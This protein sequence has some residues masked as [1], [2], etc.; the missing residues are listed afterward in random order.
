MRNMESGAG[1]FSGVTVATTSYSSLIIDLAANATQTGVSFDGGS[2]RYTMTGATARASLTGSKL[3][4]ITDGG[5]ASDG[6]LAVPVITSPPAA[7]VLPS[8][9]FS[10]TITAS[11]NPTTFASSNVPAPLIG[12]GAFITGAAPSTP[13]TYTINLSATNTAGNGNG[14]LTLYVNPTTAPVITSPSTA[15]G[16]RGQAFTTYQIVASNPPTSWNAVGLPA[17]LTCSSTGA[18]TGTPTVVGTTTVSL[19]ASNANGTGVANLTITIVNSAGGT[20]GTGG[21]AASGGGGCG[22]GAT[23]VLLFVGLALCGVVCRRR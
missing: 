5:L 16:V 2:S 23:A 14:T 8:A 15:S 10:Y 13:G 7:S 19:Q 9:A 21:S 17:G 22:A 20:S 6:G 4:S 3:W 18:S 1:C 12:S 11:E